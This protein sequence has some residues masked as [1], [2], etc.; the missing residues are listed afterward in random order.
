MVDFFVGHEF[1]HF[2]DRH[3][4]RDQILA[5]VKFN[6]V[7]E[8]AIFNQHG[9]GFVAQNGGVRPDAPEQ[10]R[11]FT[12]VAGLLAQ[13]AHGGHYRFGFARVH[14]AAGDFQFD[15]VRA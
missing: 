15:G 5:V 14:H 1:R 6:G 3:K 12:F 9:I 7:F 8:P 2:L 13:F 4:P 11:V 10:A